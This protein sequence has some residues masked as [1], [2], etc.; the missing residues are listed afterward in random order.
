MWE[1]SQLAS[2]AKRL[3]RSPCSAGALSCPWGPKEMSRYEFSLHGQEL[4]VFNLN[5]LCFI[6][7]PTLVVILPRLREVAPSVSPT[8]HPRPS[9]PS[10]LCCET[11]TQSLGWRQQALPS[12]WCPY[13]EISA[14]T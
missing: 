4:L 8:P 11:H 13:S 3:P 1:S 5:A 12:P 6:L 14:A 10:L 2:P 7:T 9:V